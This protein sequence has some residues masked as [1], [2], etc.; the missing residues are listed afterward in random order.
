LYLSTSLKT[1]SMSRVG[2]L[3]SETTTINSLIIG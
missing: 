1:L 3:T 2:T